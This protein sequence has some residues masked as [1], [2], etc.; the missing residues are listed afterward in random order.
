MA[1]LDV[2]KSLMLGRDDL[3]TVL[4]VSGY[5]NND[6]IDLSYLQPDS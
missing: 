3:N 1:A 4:L 6:L 2:A 5:R